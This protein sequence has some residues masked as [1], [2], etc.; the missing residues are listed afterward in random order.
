M[1]KYYRLNH[2]ISAPELRVIDAEGKQLGV[3][4]KEEAL[5]KALAAELDL[6]EIA[7]EAKPPVAKIIDYKKFQ[8]LEERKQK[9]ARKHTRETELKEVRVSPFIGDHDLEVALKK[10]RRFVGDGDMV[11]LSVVFKGR[12]MAHT[13]FGPRLLERILGLLNGMAELDRPGRFEGRRFVSTL[14]PN[15]N[16]VQKVQQEKT[17]EKHQAE[18]ELI[19]PNKQESHVKDEQTKN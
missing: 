13:E 9:E 8:Y 12:Q 4:S 19:E 7:P 5:K 18:K 10:V 3:I 1:K 2:Q 6:V 17:E 11:K 14:K 15:K 16:F